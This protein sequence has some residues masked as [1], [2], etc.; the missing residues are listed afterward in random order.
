MKNYTLDEL[1]ETKKAQKLMDEWLS[2]YNDEEDV[3]AVLELKYWRYEN[4]KNIYDFDDLENAIEDVEK[5]Q[6]HNLSLYGMLLRFSGW[7]TRIS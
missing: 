4:W 2:S 6:V 5:K 3:Y 1:L 7:F